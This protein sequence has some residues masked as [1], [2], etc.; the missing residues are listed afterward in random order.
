MPDAARWR[1]CLSLLIVFTTSTVGAQGPGLPLPTAAT[2]LLTVEQ[3]R[4]DAR[5]ARA[6]L[7]ESQVG[8]TWTQ[9]DNA[10]GAGFD[11]LERALVAPLSSD[12]F[13]ARLAPLISLIG[14][15]HLALER[16]RPTIGFRTRLL[17]S[18]SR[19]LPFVLR[20]V[21]ARA[22]ILA[23]LSDAPQAV[24]GAELVAVD[25][26]PVAALIDS[27]QRYLSADGRNRSFKRFQL[28]TYWR[29]HDLL[30][31][32]HGATTESRVS[33]RA[34]SRTRVPAPVTTY[35][36]RHATPRELIIRHVQRTA[37]PIDTFPPAVQ[38]RFL[39]RQAAVLQVSS[40]Y[41]GLLPKDAGSFPDAFA[42]AFRAIADSGVRELVIDVR[43]NEGGNTEHAMLL[44]SHLARQPVRTQR[45]TIVAG[46]SLSWLR[47][48]PNASD[49]VKAFAASPG[50]FVQRTADGLWAL[51][52]QFDSLNV[53][54]YVPPASRFEGR[55]HI[56][57]DGGSFSAT[58]AFIAIAASERQR[59]GRQ[60]FFVG[61][62]HGGDLR[63]GRVSGGTQ[64][65]LVLP[66]SRQTLTLSLTGTVPVVGYSP[67]VVM[68]PDVRV[69]PTGTDIARG[70][71]PVMAAV[72]ARIAQARAACRNAA[73]ASLA[74]PRTSRGRS[75]P[76]PGS[77][78]LSRSSHDRVL[79]PRALGG[80]ARR[81]VP[82]GRAAGS[83]HAR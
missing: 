36:V 81:H 38:L 49:E 22:F 1:T 68:M 69:Q 51:R 10:F 17:D 13:H 65:S 41:E 75:L 37:V 8:R 53:R 64:Q 29:F 25:G 56:L 70:I 74:C 33:V 31:L 21:D 30:E 73:T 78:R 40:F 42:R 82:V 57:T 16:S 20:I 27:M 26:V 5:I 15:G 7:V 43:G 23:D 28:G 80:T 48:A 55:V 61:E 60:V 19:Y 59:V 11:A 6:A 54:E 18:T 2:T 4:E 63:T 3:L 50:D 44:Y 52:P 62:E 35:V 58:N 9:A 39:D 24:R 32:L 67:P 83:R 14:H 45:R 47:H 71:D 12:R 76:L 79:S 46:P 66:H 34:P 72:Q 77:D